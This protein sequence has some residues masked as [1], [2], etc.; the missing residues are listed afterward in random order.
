MTR[1]GSQRH[2]KNKSKYFADGHQVLK[3]EC[4]VPSQAGG[5]EDVCS[6]IS[7]MWVRWDRDCAER[8]DDCT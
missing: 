6:R 1:V 2:G 3:L 4:E 7:E 5:A 8:A